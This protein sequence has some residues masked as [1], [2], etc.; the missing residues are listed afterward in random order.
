MITESDQC[1]ECG[2]LGTVQCPHCH[3]GEIEC[4][5]CLGYGLGSGFD[6]ACVERAFHAHAAECGAREA[7]IEMGN[8]DCYQYMECIRCKHKIEFENYRKEKP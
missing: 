4:P 8:T 5:Q 3:N 2:G 1:K 7:N 6:V